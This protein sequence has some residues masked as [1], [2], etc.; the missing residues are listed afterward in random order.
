MWG[1]NN[2]TRDI[3]MKIQEVLL[4]TYLDLSHE[5]SNL[6]SMAYSKAIIWILYAEGKPLNL[7]EIK[8]D[9][10]QLVGSNNL[11][12]ESIEEALEILKSRK[13]VFL[14]DE[15][16][17]LNPTEKEKIKKQIDYSSGVTDRIIKDRFPNEIDRSQIRNWF[18]YV[19]SQYFSAGA[20]KLIALYTSHKKPLCNVESVVKPAIKKF[21]FSK[22]EKE[23]LQ[24]YKEF[25]MSDNRE[26]GEK[27]L[28][29]MRSLLS[30]RLISAN[31]GP[32]SLSIERYRNADILLDT[33]VLFAM[34]LHR[35]EDL[36]QAFKAFSK[37]AKSLGAIISIGEFTSEEYEKVRIREKGRFIEIIN[38]YP[39]GIFEGMGQNKDITKTLLSLGCEKSDDIERFF[40]TELAIPKDIGDV[41]ISILTG[42]QLKGSYYSPESD[43]LLLKEIKEATLHKRGKEKIEDTAIH[44]LRLMKL[45]KKRRQSRNTL[46]L[47]LDGAMEAL[48]L[49]KVSE[50][51]DPLWMSLYSFIQ[52]LAINGAGPDFNPNDL[53][54]FIKMFM[55]FEEST[56]E[57]KYDERDLLLLVERAERISELPETQIVSLLN[58][59]HRIRLKRPGS[60]KEAVRLITLDLDRALR[61]NANKSDDALREKQSE[62]DSLKSQNEQMD[63]KFKGAIGELKDIKVRKIIFWFSIRVIA[64]L[65]FAGLLAWYMKSDI[66]KAY[67]QNSHYDLLSILSIVG[68]V[69]LFGITDYSTYTK[70]KLEKINNQDA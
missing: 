10:A 33:N 56:N 26:E 3:I 4:N 21:G 57:D 47:T 50:K 25:L 19:N 65:A 51:E 59:L 18:D 63:V 43:V 8:K 28:N 36:D 16:W 52:I 67:S 31:I 62:I 23:L 64:Y 69:A 11:P 60:D 15:K 13:A 66:L 2:K 22:Y 41:R 14:K 45:A 58:K 44:D 24:G 9:T 32:E 40:D 20:D 54:P 12:K 38:S 37:V 34:R 49:E 61:Y 39:K 42:A 1:G 30:S 29:L 7:D 5:G 68:A 55:E 27:V 6:R 17:D 53:A 70:P 35:G 46:V 48:A